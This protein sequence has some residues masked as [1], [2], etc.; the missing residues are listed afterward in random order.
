MPRGVPEIVPAAPGGRHISHGRERPHGPKLN[1]AVFSLQ[2]L[3]PTLLAGAR[4]IPKAGKRGH[5]SATA[6]WRRYWRPARALDQGLQPDEPR[7]QVRIRRPFRPRLLLLLTQQPPHV[8]DRR[9]LILHLLLQG[10][11]RRRRARCHSRSGG[12]SVP[13]CPLASTNTCTAGPVNCVPWIPAMNVW[14]CPD[15]AVIRQADADGV[16]VGGGAVAR[17]R[18]GTVVGAGG[19][20]EAGTATEAA[21]WLP[22]LV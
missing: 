1:A 22:V 15:A 16:R 2:N 17:R 8:L 11:R 12:V 3:W 19:G 14:F 10:E 18:R 6:T 21:L 9:L 7:A 5:G 4:R 20:Q 13:N